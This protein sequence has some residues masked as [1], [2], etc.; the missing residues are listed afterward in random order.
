M[1]WLNGSWLDLT[2]DRDINDLYKKKKRINIK[3]Y[4]IILRIY[5]LMLIF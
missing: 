2:K 1:D 4:F 3:L 5:C